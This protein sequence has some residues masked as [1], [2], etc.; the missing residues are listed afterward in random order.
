MA[1]R[2]SSLKNNGKNN[3]SAVGLVPSRKALTLEVA[4]STEAVDID[5]WADAYVRAVARSLQALNPKAA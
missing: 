4:W 5:A 3:G 1:K 2:P